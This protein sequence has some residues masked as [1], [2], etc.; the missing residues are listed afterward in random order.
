MLGRWL[1]RLPQS[2]ALPL[3]LLVFFAIALA[4]WLSPRPRLHRPLL[5]FL[6]PPLLLAGCIGAGFAL[7]SIAA[8]VSGNAD[9]SFAHPLALRVALGFGVWTMALLTMRRAGAISSWLWLAGLGVTAAVLAPGVSPYFLFPCLIAAPLLLLTL[10]SGR[11]PALFLAALCAMLAWIG[12]AAGS[13]AIMGLSAHFLFTVPVA[14]ALIA[15]L[16]LLSLQKIGEGAWRLSVLASLLIALGAAIVAGY[17]PAYSTTQP[18]RLNLRYAEKDGKSFWIADPV[19]HLPEELRKAA[20]FSPAPQDLLEWRGYIAPAG[21]VTLPAPSASISRQGN[22]LTLDL[23]GSDAASGM[24]VLISGGLE[25]VTVGGVRTPASGGEIIW[26]CATRDC[27]SARVTLDFSGPV[28]KSLLLVEQRT[29]LP[30]KGAALL[31][32]RPN[33][34]TPSQMGDVSVI[35]TD[36]AIPPSDFTSARVAAQVGQSLS[37]FDAALKEAGW[38]PVLSGAHMWDGT[39]ERLYGNAG[40][41]F[42][43]GFTGVETC[44]GTGINVCVFNYNRS[45]QCLRL[46]TRGEYKKMSYEPILTRLETVCVTP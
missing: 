1:P 35:A 7:H 8:L 31:K 45:G 20:R 32:A 44:S 11:A 5:S 6:M 18:Q 16:P 39:I 2:W 15:V 26:N 33:W 19:A 42:R 13:E 22:R 43:A 4:G 34:V 24:S 3:A 14:I 23:H 40:D 27:A 17:Q 36:V 28:P 10:K 9:P 38:Q 12:L 46:I 29:G 41:I 21:M 37:E 30:A 25:A